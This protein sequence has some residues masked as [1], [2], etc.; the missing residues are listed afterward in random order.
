MG[1]VDTNVGAIQVVAPSDNKTQRIAYVAGTSKPE[2]IGLARAGSSE[3][4]ALWQIKKLVYS[5]DNVIS[6]LYADGN[7]KYDNVWTTPSGRSYS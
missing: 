7:A 3:A 6:V 1:E 4:A 2:Y 5:G